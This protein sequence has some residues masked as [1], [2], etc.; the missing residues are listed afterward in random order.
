MA[1]SSYRQRYGHD[2]TRICKANR[3]PNPTSRRKSALNRLM[4]QTKD[5]N[6]VVEHYE[7]VE[8]KKTGKSERVRADHP[9][10]SEAQKKRIL[11]EIETLKTRI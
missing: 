3:G 2:R 8:N 6:K 1:K 10:Y 9:L 7:V 4:E 11:R 5:F